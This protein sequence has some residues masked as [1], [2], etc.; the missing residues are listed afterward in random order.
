MPKGVKM[1]GAEYTAFTNSEWGPGWYW[2]ETLFL[3]NGEE[4]DDIG[5]V[6]PD[7][8]IVILDGVIYKGSDY[9]ADTVSALTFA[10]RW[11]KAQT[12][13]SV[14]VEVPNECVDAFKAEMKSL[15]HRVL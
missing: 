3:L 2:D 1:T 9:K 4:V 13:T 5:T 7:D 8:K 14:T 10:R 6:Q 12:V 15:G 11:L